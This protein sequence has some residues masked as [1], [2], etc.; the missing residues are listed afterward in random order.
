MI[1]CSPCLSFFSALQRVFLCQTHLESHL[2]YLEYKFIE[3]VYSTG[4]KNA[5]C[6]FQNIN[7]SVGFNC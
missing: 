6:L 3:S 5:L 1:F 2:S 4:S 7:Y